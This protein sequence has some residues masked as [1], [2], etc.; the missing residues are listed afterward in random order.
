MTN[1]GT[2]PKSD[3]ADVA[4]REMALVEDANAEG[5]FALGVTSKSLKRY[6]R[7]KYQNFAMSAALT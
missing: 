6:L 1:I 7:N 5:D 3:V 2:F 4:A